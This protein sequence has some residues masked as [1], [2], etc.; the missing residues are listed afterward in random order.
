MRTKQ[1][2]FLRHRFFEESNRLSELVTGFPEGRWD[3][4]ETT[5]TDKE[6]KTA[7]SGSLEVKRLADRHYA[8]VLVRPD[9]TKTDF[10]APRHEADINASAGVLVVRYRFD[11][12]PAKPVVR[13]D[14]DRNDGTH[15]RGGRFARRQ[16]PG[17]IRE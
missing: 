7:S 8:A 15:A 9:S 16:P 3:V 5:G 10:A 14:P 1:H 11:D 2:R 17:L 13:G 6:S 12:G 4:T